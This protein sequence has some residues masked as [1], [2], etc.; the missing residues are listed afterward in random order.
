[1]GFE[2]C[3][4]HPTP[5]SAPPSKRHMKGKTALL[6]VCFTLIVIALI[7]RCRSPVLFKWTPQE[8]TSLGA[9]G[10]GV[11]A[12]HMLG[13]ATHDMLFSIMLAL[14]LAALSRGPFTFW[15]IVVLIAGEILHAIFGVRSATFKW[16]FVE[17]PP[18]QFTNSLAYILLT[19]LSVAVLAVSLFHPPNSAQ[20]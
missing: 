3:S 7:C 14:V 9:S 6:A 8:D 19:V 16:L 18:V 2:V 5:F 10:K 1:M 15:F 4:F 17:R 20:K 11:H 13:V 12:D